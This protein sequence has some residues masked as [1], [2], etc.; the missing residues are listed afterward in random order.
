VLDKLPSQI[1]KL[2]AEVDDVLTEEVA[3]N[4]GENE[5]PP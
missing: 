3:K 4:E 2:L 1:S 5:N